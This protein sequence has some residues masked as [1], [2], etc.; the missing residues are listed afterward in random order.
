MFSHEPELKTIAFIP[1][2]LGSTRLPEKPLADIAGKPMVQRVWEGVKDSQHISRTVIVT[3]S[4]EIKKAAETFD[5]ECV[6]TPPELPSGTDRIAFAYKELDLDYD[7]IV[8]I[9]GD[10]PLITGSDLD[11]LIV[12]LGGSLA[13]ASTLVKRIK[14]SGDITNPNVVKVVTQTDGTA[15]YFSRSAIPF[16]RN[17]RGGID[18]EN[19]TYYKHI[20]IYA[21]RE[22]TL[23][24]FV[25]LP[26]SELEQTESLEQLR[27][28]QNNYKMLCIETDSEFISVDT[29]DDLARASQFFSDK[30]RKLK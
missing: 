1:A 21:Y 24:A 26:P 4:E 7:I 19:Q 8:N 30:A 3:D 12:G 6:M 2:R 15:L 28:L 11:K 18:L 13:N 5:A 20:G 10:E 17:V 27:L 16:A 22:Q 14:A 23:L 29:S 25:N 9:Q